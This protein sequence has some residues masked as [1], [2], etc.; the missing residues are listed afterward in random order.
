MNKKQVIGKIP[1]NHRGDARQI[2]EVLEKKEGEFISVRKIADELK[3]G[4]IR[5]WMVCEAILKTSVVEKKVAE[6]EINYKF[7]GFGND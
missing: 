7:L 3:I 2:L 5:T 1:T 6:E 4:K